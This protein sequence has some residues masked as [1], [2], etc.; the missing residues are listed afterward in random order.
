MNDTKQGAPLVRVIY[1]RGIFNLPRLAIAQHSNMNGWLTVEHPDG[2]WVSLADLKPHFPSQ[3]SHEQLVVA[4]ATAR[5]VLVVSCG[6]KAPYV[7][8]ALDDIDAA[9]KQAGV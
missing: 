4:L 8:I 3:Q 2:G 9:L 5:K 6:E 1:D 7:R